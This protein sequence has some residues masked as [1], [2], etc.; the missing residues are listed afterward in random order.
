MNEPSEQKSVTKLEK[1]VEDVLIENNLQAVLYYSKIL[2]NW[3]ILVGKPLAVKTS[4][5]KLVRKTLFVTVE[6]A[7]YSHHLK[8]YEKQLLDLIASPEICGE[9][10]VKKILFR[11]GQPSDTLSA[12]ENE[13]LLESQKYQKIVEVSDDALKTSNQIVDKKLKS[14]F[15][16]FMSSKQI[17]G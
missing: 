10:A 5:E 15:S 1:A 13:V 4:P 6:D 11:V 2:K 17:K 8:Y 9:G 7:A 12:E 3:E 14:S 16:R